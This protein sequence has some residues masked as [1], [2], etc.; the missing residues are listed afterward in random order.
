VKLIRLPEAG[1]ADEVER[2]WRAHMEV[3]AKNLLWADL[4]S[5]SVIDLYT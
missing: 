3:A 1:D 2:F 4:A 5:E